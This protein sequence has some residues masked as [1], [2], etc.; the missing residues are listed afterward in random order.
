MPRRVDV[1]IADMLLDPGNARLGQEQTSQQATALALAKQQGRRLVKLA[2]SV[3]NKGLDPA[4][5]PVV[6][7]TND[8]RRSYKVIEGNRRVLALKALDTPSLV[9]SVLT[10]SEFRKLMTLS[11]K[12]AASPIDEVM[13]VLFD[14]DEEQAAYEWVLTRHIGA[15]D[16]AGLVEWDAD[17]K[18]RF[19][20]RH[21]AKG[22]RNYA[23]QALDFLNQVDGQST[24]PTKIS[25]NV[26]RL[27]KSEYVRDKLGLDRVNGEL[28]SN[29]PVEEVAK[30]LRK[31]AEDLRTQA[32]KVPDIY[33]DERRR[34]YIDGFT[35]AHLP[36]K[37]SRLKDPVK[38]TDLPSGK[39]KPVAPRP[40]PRPKPKQPRTTVAPNDSKLNPGPPRINSI[41]NELVS[42]SAELYPNAGFVL[43]RVFVE[44]SVDDYLET[45]KLMTEV[46][47]RNKPLALRLKTAADHLHSTHAIDAQLKKAVYKIA[48]SRSGIAAGITT[49]NQYVHNKYV[50][51]LPS[52]LR[53]TWDELQPLLEVIWK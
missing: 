30:G 8:K 9:Q 3:T 16:G 23:G 13:C 31:I 24:S 38:L 39:A 35:R 4:Q 27:L 43:L 21:G 2:E 29:Y 36:K 12:F 45:H 37:S 50:H 1:P 11:Q 15:Q 6:V 28:V 40:K 41:Y 51:P 46:D 49:F 34:T 19:A 44:L 32:I 14:A 5:L 18:D 47:R 22:A 42:M 7:A 52:E 17:E 20:A 25:T 10:A 26:Q 48:D 53:T 33:D